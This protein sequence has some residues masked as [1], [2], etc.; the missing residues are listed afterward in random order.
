MNALLLQPWRVVSPADKLFNYLL[1]EQ[2]ILD[3]DW[4]VLRFR[5]ALLLLPEVRYV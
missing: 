4:V 2:L 1:S 3:P 5:S